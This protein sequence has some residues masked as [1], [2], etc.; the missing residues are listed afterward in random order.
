MRNTRMK[1]H[2]A[3]KD[4]KRNVINLRKERLAEKARC[5]FGKALWAELK[6][7]NRSVRC[8]IHTIDGQRT[9][10]DIVEHLATKYRR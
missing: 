10:T 3:G 8:P 7:L 2:Q 6:R 9:N 5:T 1:Y 4:I